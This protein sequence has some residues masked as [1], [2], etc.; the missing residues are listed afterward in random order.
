MSEQLQNFDKAEIIDMKNLIIFNSFSQ[1]LR[2]RT[3]KIGFDCDHKLETTT[4][5]CIG[6]L[7]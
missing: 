2:V 4:P 7:P 3:S 1:V 6:D 5:H